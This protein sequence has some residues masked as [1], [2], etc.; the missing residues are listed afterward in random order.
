VPTPSGAPAE[1]AGRAI[2]GAV[3]RVRF[4]SNVD[5][6]LRDHQVAIATLVVAGERLGNARSAAQR[7]YLA[8]WSYWIRIFEE[9]TR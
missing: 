4:I 7:V 6:S 8:G 9:V 1:P 3:A 2:V 5:T